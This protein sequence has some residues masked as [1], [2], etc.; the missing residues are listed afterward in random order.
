MEQK[1]N[2]VWEVQRPGGGGRLDGQSRITGKAAFEPEGNK[3]VS[4]ADSGE[5]PSLAGG[6]E[7]QSQVESAGCWGEEHGGGEAGVGHVR[8]SAGPPGQE[9]AGQ[10]T[11]TKLSEGVTHTWVWLPGGGRMWGQGSAT[12]A[13]AQWGGEGRWRGG[14]RETC[15]LPPARL[16]GPGAEY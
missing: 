15:P 12:H 10:T 13:E 7:G 9:V 6:R 5:R 11:R 3:R 4:P 16:W 8:G 14:L 1:W 2:G